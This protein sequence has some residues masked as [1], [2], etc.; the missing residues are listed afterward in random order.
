MNRLPIV[1]LLIL[2]NKGYTS[3]AEYKK[4]KDYDLAVKLTEFAYKH[5]EHPRFHNVALIV[6]ESR[7]QE[8]VCLPG[9][10]NMEDYI[11]LAF[12]ESQFDPFTIGSAKEIGTWQILDWRKEM[13]KL[14]ASNPFDIS[15]NGDMMCSVLK[16]KYRIHR[17]YKKAMQA[18]NGISIFKGYRYYNHVQGFKKK[19]WPELF[20]TTKKGKK[21]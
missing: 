14:R 1:A 10:Y 13:Y 8:K 19:M 16:E 3:E 21:V 2:V 18:Y 4:D 9:I 12:V 11:S 15:V 17:K 6:K 5:G 7:R 20:V